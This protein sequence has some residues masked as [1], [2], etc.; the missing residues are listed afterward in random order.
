M[1]SYLYQSPCIL[2]HFPI[3]F[4]HA[5]KPHPNPTKRYNKNT[6]TTPNRTI[7]LTF[8]HHIRRLRPLLRTLKS[9]ALP[10][11]RSVL[12]TSKSILSPLSS[13]LSMFS[14]IMSFTLSISRLAAVRLSAGGAVL[15]VLI[16]S[17][18][19]VLKLAVP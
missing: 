2:I 7:S 19:V 13:T 12:S 16:I 11:S 4:P 8:F 5:G 6:T 14:V 10:P 1:R 18:N 15:Y 3:H 9:R 17:F